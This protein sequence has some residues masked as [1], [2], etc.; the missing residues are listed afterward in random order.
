MT[1]KAVA[2]TDDYIWDRRCWC[3]GPYDDCLY[4]WAC[5]AARFEWRKDWRAFRK[6]SPRRP[7][8]PQAIKA[9]ASVVPQTAGLLEAGD[10]SDDEET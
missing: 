3:G 7:S 4:P 2:P 6:N 1:K 8:A 10:D 9:T 5:Y